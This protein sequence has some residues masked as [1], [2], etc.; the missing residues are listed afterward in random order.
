MLRQS[1]AAFFISKAL[2]NLTVPF[3]IQYLIS[4]EIVKISALDT[5]N[6]FYQKENRDS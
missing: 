2:S 5:Q 3:G 6:L 1:F 4:K